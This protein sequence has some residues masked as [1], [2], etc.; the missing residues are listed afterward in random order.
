MFWTGSIRS[1]CLF[2]Y[3]S[4]ILTYS[5]EALF[6]PL[7]P[8]QFILCT[9]LEHLIILQVQTEHIFQE[10]VGQQSQRLLRVNG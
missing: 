2:R 6:L 7:G 8:Q 5:I 4:Q 9:F 3:L 10:M 1:C